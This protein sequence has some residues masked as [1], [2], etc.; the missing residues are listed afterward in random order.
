MDC[1]CRFGIKI[2]VPYSD[3]RLIVW[4]MERK[5]IISLKLTVMREENISD[6][7]HITETNYE[8]AED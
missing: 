2:I 4:I 7:K 5:H 1:F 8:G 3:N 6:A